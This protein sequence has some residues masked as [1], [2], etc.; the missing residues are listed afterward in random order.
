MEVYVSTFVPD[1]SA[2]APALGERFPVSHGDAIFPGPGQ[3]LAWRADSKALLYGTPRGVM[4][5]ES[6]T[7]AGS[8]FGDPK[9]LFPLTFEGGLTGDIAPD[10]RRA[11]VAV[12]AAAAGSIAGINVVLN[13]QSSL[14]K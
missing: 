3:G 5:S 10:G 6:T 9:L 14:P 4:V 11:L 1:S 8:P 12:P 13:W 2:Q 7:D